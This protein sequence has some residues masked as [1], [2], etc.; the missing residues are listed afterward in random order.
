MHGLHFGR[1]LAKIAYLI[2]VVAAAG[3][4]YLVQRFRR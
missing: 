1:A 4:I 2:V 3:I